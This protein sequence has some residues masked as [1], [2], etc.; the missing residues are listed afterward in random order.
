V[1]LEWLR[2]AA[3]LDRRRFSRIGRRLLA[4]NLLVLFVPIAG[5][6]YLDVY[7][8]R[9]LQTQ[10]RGMVQQARMVAAALAG[11]GVSGET[12]AAFLAAVEDRGEARISVYDAAGRLVD[13]SSRIA[14][15]APLRGTDGY[16]QVS[17]PRRRVIYRVGAWIV[18][19]RDL[20]AGRVRH[21]LGRGRLQPSS[22]SVGDGTPV[23][24]SVALLGRYGA[25]ARP[26]PGQRSLTLNSAVPVRQAGAVIGAVVVSQ[27]TFRILQAL[28]DVRLRL[29]EIVLVSLAFA[30]VLTLVASATIVTPVVRLQEAAAALTARRRELAGFFSR[31]ERS[32]EIG[33]LA[34]SLETLAARFE[35]HIRAAEG[36]AADVAHEI[37]NPLAAIR[38]AAET[39]AE[40]SVPAERE[41]FLMMLLQD[42]DRLDRLVSGVREMAHVDAQLST[43]A[44]HVLDVRPL[45][46]GLASRAPRDRAVEVRV[47]LVRAPLLVTGSADR[48]QQVFENL[49]DNAASLSAP[50]SVVEIEAKAAPDVVITISDRGP[51]IPETHLARVFDRFFSYRPDADR[52]THMGLGLAIA[53]AIT[54][55]HGGTI[56]VRNRPGGGAEFSVRLPAAA[57]VH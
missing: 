24:V 17:D 38:T 40:A 32:D 33:D 4:F 25:A 11:P 37:R 43:E 36:F 14:D 52:R 8:S 44:R 30:A 9:L 47:H 20:I 45:L 35:A 50:G 57:G 41:R 2:R 48:L 53:K 51:G 46:E 23:E 12:V 49:V 28:Y 16:S 22:I 10:E 19:A 29:F 1:T 31:V 27:S 13:D 26:T 18:G 34:R 39:M 54:E 56:E 5:M 55:G 42:V 15:R 6:L 3:G 21:L 7:E